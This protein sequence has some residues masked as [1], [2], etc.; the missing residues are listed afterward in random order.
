[1]AE[2]QKKRSFWE[3]IAQQQ[4][5][6]NEARGQSQSNKEL[7]LLSEQE[8]SKLKAITK[9]SYFKAGL[10]GAL[11]VVL[12]Y[13]P[14][15]LFASVLFPVSNVWIPFYDNYIEVEI[16]F[17]IYSAILVVLEISYL[18]Y[19]NINAVAAI[20]E[21]CG[22]PNPENESYQTQLNALIA[23]SLEKQQKQLQTLGINPYKGLTGIS[24]LLFQTLLKLKAA[25]SNV[26]FTLL[27]KKLLGRYALRQFID[28]AGIPIYAFWNIWGVKK[29][30]DEAKVRVMAPPL[31]K[32]CAELIY[33]EQKDNPEFISHLFDTLQLISESKRDFH[34]NHFLFSSTLLKQFELEIKKEPEYNNN[35]QKQIEKFSPITKQAIEK[36]YI[37]GIMIDGKISPREKRNLQILF[38]DSIFKYS[39]EDVIKWSNGFSQGQAMEAYFHTFFPD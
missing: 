1:M 35:F 5:S 9:T 8:L 36:V 22:H 7:T 19:I 27:I 18:T 37:F 6:Q 29:V 2:I 31:I 16:S 12:L 33:R 20:A 14:Y 30:M 26:I 3:K 11:G 28:F 15:H 17:L 39:T 38:T 24:M 10:V 21:A 25:V 23:V 4:I 34:F 13:L 32:Q